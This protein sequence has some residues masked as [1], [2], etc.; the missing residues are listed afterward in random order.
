MRCGNG[1]NAS[2]AFHYFLFHCGVLFFVIFTVFLWN[3]KAV[4]DVSYCL[5][6][7]SKLNRDPG[8]ILYVSGHAF[9]NSL[10]PE[11]CVPIKAFKTDDMGEVPLDTAL[12]DL[13]PFLECELNFLFA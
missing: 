8:K 3:G 5:Q 11:N 6:D 1:G 4:F 9:E 2:K 10:Q 12:L 13:I 7:L